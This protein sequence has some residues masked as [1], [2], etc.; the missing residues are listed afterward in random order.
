MSEINLN[1]LKSLA[2]FK[3]LYETG[4]ATRTAKSLGIT[5]PGVSRSLAQLEQNLGMPLFTRHKKRLVPLPEAEELY[6]E[7][8][9]LMANLEEMKHSIVALRE[10]GVS[11]MRLA[12]A[13]GLA[14]AYVPQ[15]IANILKLNPGYN[16]FL[17]VLPTPN[18]VR[19]VEGGQFDV[20]FVTLP[21]ASQSL[22]IEEFCAVDAVCILPA[23]HAL[24]QKAHID[25]TDLQNQHIVIPNQPNLAAD[26]LL[27]QI[28][29]H[30]IAISGKT[31]SNI[32]SI[33]SL[34]ANGVGISLLNPITAFDLGGNQNIV[35]RPF[36]PTFTYSFGLIYKRNW[37]G[38]RMLELIRQNQPQ[39]THYLGD[40]LTG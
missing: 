38:S 40:I 14:F 4:T 37:R 3:T 18:V 28:A 21:V 17:D 1:S 32:A 23:D 29:K 6:N 34:V 12:V 27:Q 19:A 30:N 39:L 16:V 10:F 2:I 36:S 35:V 20:G 15:I 24:A 22:I 26:A 5:Q 11:R 33:C 9:G 13:P 7:V 25:I 8:L 31:E